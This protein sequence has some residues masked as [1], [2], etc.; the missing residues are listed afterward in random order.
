[1][2][3]RSG[4]P[5]PPAPASASADPASWA[6]DS[7]PGMGWGWGD[8]GEADWES[9]TRRK[10]K[11]A[12]I[13]VEQQQF[14]HV[15]GHFVTGVTVITT[16]VDEQPIGMTAQSFVSLSLDPP[17][18]MF[19]PTR[20]SFTWEQ[21]ESQGMLCINV[22]SRSQE[23]VSR[24]FASRA[25]ERFDGIDWTPAPVSGSPLLSAVHAWIDCELENVYAGGDHLIAVC[26]VLALAAP[27]E[28]GV[29]LVFYLGKYGEVTQAET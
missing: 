23:E 10:G 21:I 9:A 3:K 18:V 26:R 13:S 12:P 29:P 5:K 28:S 6:L 27:A 4:D 20:N 7:D 14:R 24:R 16:I 17:L 25:E 22:L 19:C 1:M 2:P 15:M 8:H 11:A